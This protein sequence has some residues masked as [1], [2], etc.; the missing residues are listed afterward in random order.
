MPPPQF[1]GFRISEKLQTTGGSCIFQWVFFSEKKVTSEMLGQPKW[2]ANWINDKLDSRWSCNSDAPWSIHWPNPPFHTLA[3]RSVPYIGQPPLFHTLANLPCPIH[4]PNLP[5]PYIA[6]ISM[7]HTLADL[8]VSYHQHLNV[9][10]LNP[11]WKITGLRWL[12]L[13]RTRTMNTGG[14]VWTVDDSKRHAFFRK[15]KK[16]Y[17][18]ITISLQQ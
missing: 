1:S 9:E 15:N 17:Y 7:F 11:V 6:Q 5:V 18:T 10:A 13:Q 3:N 2:R 16:I 12:P 8:P 14:N 4:C